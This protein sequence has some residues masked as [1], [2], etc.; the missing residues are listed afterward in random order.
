MHVVVSGFPPT[1]FVAVRNPPSKA[2]LRVNPLAASRQ[3]DEAK[4]PAHETCTERP[5]PF[6]DIP[7]GQLPS[8]PRL[9]RP[10]YG[11]PVK[12]IQAK[13]PDLL[14]APRH[15]SGSAAYGSDGVRFGIVCLDDLVES[16]DL[17]YLAN[18]TG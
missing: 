1:L 9:V 5:I 18:R 3:D 12:D 11:C 7:L 16:A 8:A 10:E 13:G 2:P 4:V 6:Q 15:S 17:E 14:G